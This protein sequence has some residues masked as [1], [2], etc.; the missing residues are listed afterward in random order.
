MKGNLSNLVLALVLVLTPILAGAEGAY[1][2]SKCGAPPQ[3]PEL[4]PVTGQAMNLISDH[5]AKLAVWLD[6]A[7]QKARDDGDW[8][9]IGVVEHAN[10]LWVLEGLQRVRDAGY[11][12]SEYVES[13]TD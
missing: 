11:P 7:H 10:E 2:R 3:P 12:T 6:C 13:V 1:V 5:R 9:L 4:L 8:G